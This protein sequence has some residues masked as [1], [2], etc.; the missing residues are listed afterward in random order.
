M[1]KPAACQRRPPE[2]GAPVFDE[3]AR[4]VGCAQVS[5]EI[6]ELALL[7]PC[8]AEAA[9]PGQFVNVLVP[10]EGFGQRV[11][12][13]EGAWRESARP[14]RPILVRRPFSVCRVYAS[15]D[16]GAP[17]T[18][19]LLVKVVG[20]GTR[21]LVGSEVGTE[22]QVLGPLGVPFELPPAGAAAALVA[23]GCGWAA[24]DM[25]ARELRR[26]DHPTY[27]FIGAE[28]ADALPLRT[29]QGTRPSGF[30]DELPESCVTSRELE[31]LGIAVG[32][33]AERG[34]QL[35]GGLVTDLL[36]RFLESEHGRG[37]HVYACGPWAMLRRVAE[38]AGGRD[39][40][41]QLSFEK[42]MACGMG[43][44]MSCVC[45][46][47]APDGTSAHKRLC[48]DGPIL[49]AEEVDWEAEMRDS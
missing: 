43:V 40:P 30:L 31:D 32:L 21:R 19:E 25:L 5:G 2:S 34:G 4:L 18:I 20:E 16:A 29:I 36:E 28:T 7:S 46:V 44:C 13:S 33:A 49:R 45:E 14:S 41:C 9:R 6:F 38:L 27:A 1:N 22:L 12:E 17:D 23:G 47:V 15:A 11:F 26:R 35:Y 42:R 3:S 10:C 24:L 48:V 39:V 37:A 8:I